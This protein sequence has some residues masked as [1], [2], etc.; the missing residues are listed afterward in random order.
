MAARYLTIVPIPGPAASR[1]GPGAAAA[2]FPVVGLAVSPLMARLF[3]ATASGHGARF[4]ADLGRVGPPLA[5]AFAFAVAL[6]VL[7]AAGALALVIAVVLALVIA[8]FMT[9]RIGGLSGDV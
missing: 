3:P 5:M 8:A 1:E 4:R 7:G 2:W 9:R 6:G